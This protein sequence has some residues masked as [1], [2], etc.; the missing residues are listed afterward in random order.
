MHSIVEIRGYHGNR[1]RPKPVIEHS[2]QCSVLEQYIYLGKMS[3]LEEQIVPISSEFYFDP[4]VYVCISRASLA[5][6]PNTNRKE[7]RS[8]L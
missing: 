5:S 2:T 4:R 8:L 1:A 3:D 7:Y 6:Y